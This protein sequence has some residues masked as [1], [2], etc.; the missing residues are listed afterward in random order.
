MSS[1]M[2]CSESGCDATWRTP[3]GLSNILKGPGK[4]VWRCAAHRKVSDP[5]PHRLDLRLAVDRH[6]GAAV[7][8]ERAR[9]RELLETQGFDATLRD[10]GGPTPSLPPGANWRER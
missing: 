9:L 2:V 7:Q 6:A 3:G 10:L 1:T 5:S 4:P 8:Q